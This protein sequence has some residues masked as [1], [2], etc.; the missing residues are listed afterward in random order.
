[1]FPTENQVCLPLKW[2]ALPFNPSH[3]VVFVPLFTGSSYQHALYQ[4]S[5]SMV[6]IPLTQGVNL[7]KLLSS[8]FQGVTESP[9]CGD[10]DL[11]SG[12]RFLERD[13]A[14]LN[15][16]CKIAD[17]PREVRPIS[18]L[19]PTAATS[20]TISVTAAVDQLPWPRW[21]GLS[22]KQTYFSIVYI[23]NHPHI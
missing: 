11:T 6:N 20:S 22:K 23:M 21:S 12:E 8:G 5:P 4:H 18:Q 1:M 10:L 9:A 2:P 13:L 17:V 3:D 19:W 14:F 16:K 7:A 15:A